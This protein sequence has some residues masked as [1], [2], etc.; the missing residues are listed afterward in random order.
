[1]LAIVEQQQDL[2]GTEQPGQSVHSRLIG[3]RRERQRRGYGR[4]HQRRISERRQIDAGNPIAEVRG[5][6]LRDGEGQAGLAYPAG[7]G[8]GQEGGGFIEQE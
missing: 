3:A 2:L 8:Q 5:H 1:V 4:R 6:I 7:T